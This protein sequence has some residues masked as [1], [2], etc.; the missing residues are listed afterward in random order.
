M[1][2]LAQSTYFFEQSLF[3]KTPK[4]Y[5]KSPEELPYDLRY[6]HLNP[7][8][9]AHLASRDR[10]KEQAFESGR[11]SLL[12]QIN[13]T[14]SL[15]RES[16]LTE[17]EAS[18]Y[19]FEDSKEHSLGL[20]DQLALV[21]Y[22]FDLV[23]PSLPRVLEN[24]LQS[25]HKE[26]IQGTRYIPR[27]WQCAANRE[28]YMLKHGYG[29][30]SSPDDRES[31]GLSVDSED[32]GGRDRS[33]DTKSRSRSKMSR[34]NTTI[35]GDIVEDEEATSTSRSDGGGKAADQFLTTPHSSSRQSVSQN[36]RHP[37]T[38]LEKYKSG[39]RLD[40]RPGSGK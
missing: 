25:N 35:L 29:S 34:A 13:R 27:D 12:P 15:I 24:H 2:H 19:R 6:A 30:E 1:D 8:V 7:R 39:M 11:K 16:L 23:K 40:N 5:K 26:L 37:K 9:A 17:E 31:L 38:R 22:K 33:P 32:H 20:L 36:Q 3:R 18:R 10:E 21:L 14:I 28:E 4:R